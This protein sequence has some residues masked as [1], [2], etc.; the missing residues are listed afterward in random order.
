MKILD[1][2]LRIK[3]FFKLLLASEVTRLLR[4]GSE[5]APLLV[6]FNTKC[7]PVIKSFNF[8]NFWTKHKDFKK[9]EED[10]WKIEFVESS[11]I[12]VQIK[13]K[14]SK[15]CFGIVEEKGI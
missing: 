10:N 11:F 4:K 3:K 8:L 13:M 9:I 14:K 1:K 2:I 15:S 5:H 7:E 12:E 6:K